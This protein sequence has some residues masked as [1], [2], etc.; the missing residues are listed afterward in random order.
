MVYI[1]DH[2]PL[3]SEEEKQLEKIITLTIRLG[4]EFYTSSVPHR[5]KIVNELVKQLNEQKTTQVVLGQSARSRF[6]EIVKGSVVEHLLRKIRHTSVWIVADQKNQT[7][8][9]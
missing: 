3:T 2:I 1:Q 5:R 6:Q 4:G 9:S 7:E 8:S